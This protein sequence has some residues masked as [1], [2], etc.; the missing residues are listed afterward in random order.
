MYIYVYNYIYVYIYIYICIYIYISYSITTCIWLTW[1][2]TTVQRLGWTSTHWSVADVP[3]I[4]FHDAEWRQFPAPDSGTS[5]AWE[6]CRMPNDA[7][8]LVSFVP[9]YPCPTNRQE[10]FFRAMDNDLQVYSH[11]TK[12]QVTKLQIPWPCCIGF[13]TTDAVTLLATIH[14]EPRLFCKISCPYC[15][16][17]SSAEPDYPQNHWA[18]VPPRTSGVDLFTLGSPFSGV[19]IYSKPWI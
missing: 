11:T 14:A 10:S 9:Q 12:H 1:V 8:W 6:E 16:M 4:C 15:E 5:W 3:R 18:D 2:V 19:C 7:Q 17:G 13:R